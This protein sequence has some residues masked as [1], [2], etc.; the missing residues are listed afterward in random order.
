HTDAALAVINTI[1]RHVPEAI[2]GAGTV[3]TPEQLQYVKDAGAQFAVSPGITVRLLTAARRLEVALLPGVA[4]A[5]EVQLALEVGY[6]RLKFFQQKQPGGRRSCR[7][8]TVLSPRCAS[9]PLVAFIHNQRQ[10]ISSCQML[11]VSVARGLP[12]KT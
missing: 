5:S 9:A 8:C 3:L 4:S 6:E 12:R 1:A 2:V 11:P 10:R 7:L